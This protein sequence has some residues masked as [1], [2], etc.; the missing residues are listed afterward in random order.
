MASRYPDSYYDRGNR[1]RGREP[2]RDRHR[3]RDDRP[4]RKGSFAAMFFSTL[5]L[6]LAIGVFCFAAYKLVGFYRNYKAA[7]DEY[8]KLNDQFVNEPADKEDTP[9][10]DV[11]SAD[12]E[13]AKPVLTDVR[14]LEDPQ[15]VADMVAGA[16]T[17]ETV[18]NKV[19]R[20]LP[21]LKNP[22]NFQELHQ[23]NTDVIAWIRIGALDISY[24]VAQAGDNDYYLHRTFERQDNFVGCI[25]LNCD[26]SRFFTDQNSIIYGHNMKNGSMFGSLKKFRDQA[27]YDS[28]P[29]FW[30][31]TEDLIYQYRIFTATEVPTTG[32]PYRIRFTAGDFAAFLQNMQASSFIDTHEVQVTSDDRI[33]T[34]STCTGNETVRFILE[35]KL[36]QIYISD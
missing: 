13:E 3:D 14:E 16:A 6:V 12:Q 35:G 5:L 21:L 34:L 8:D 30:I 7:S 10:V 24:P 29:Y 26:N 28:N 2:R 18:E 4:Q 33:V 36:E 20:T 17:R 15:T 1:R 25:F 23:I 31:F 22:I 11:Q 19:T 32:D 9:A 27:L